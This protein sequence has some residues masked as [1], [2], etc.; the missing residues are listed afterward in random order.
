MRAAVRRLAVFIGLA[1]LFLWTAGVGAATARSVVVMRMLE[2]APA[3]MSA[4]DEDDGSPGSPGAPSSAVELEEEESQS[5]MDD[6]LVG[7][8]TS[9]HS[10]SW[11][12]VASA[13]P[14]RR[15]KA[16]LAIDAP[17]R[18]FETEPATPPPRG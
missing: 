12:A 11:S 16:P 17:Y 18:S 3:G 4:P 6:G 10:D 7:H 5:E 8:V 15:A 13:W 14:G 1:L 2:R 9:I